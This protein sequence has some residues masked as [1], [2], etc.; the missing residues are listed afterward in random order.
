MAAGFAFAGVTKP[1]TIVNFLDVT[2]NW[3]GT[4]MVV[5]GV[6]VTVTF[7]LFRVI[8]RTRERPLLEAKF[9]IPTRRDVDWRLLVGASLFGLGWGLIGFCPGPALASLA[10]GSTELYVWLGGV[11][12]GMYAFREF[13]RV[14]QSRGTKRGQVASSSA[15]DTVDASR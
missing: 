5:M 8:W 6:A 7:I 2:G 9:S 15:N 1:E 11:V 4:V 14:L 12:V 13:D 10:T 3:D